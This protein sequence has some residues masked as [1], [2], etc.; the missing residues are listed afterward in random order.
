MIQR[1][2]HTVFF[3]FLCHASSNAAPPPYLMATTKHRGRVTRETKGC[4]RLTP[5]SHFV[6]VPA[7]LRVHYVSVCVPHFEAKN[8][9][10]LSCFEDVDSIHLPC[11]HTNQPATAAPRRSSPLA[12]FAVT[13]RKAAPFVLPRNCGIKNGTQSRYHHS[14]VLPQYG[15]V[16]ITRYLDRVI[17]SC[18]RSLLKK[19]ID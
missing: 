14:P 15:S 8:F 18:L 12:T 1:R 11:S 9:C 2:R 16:H 10:I 5:F 17:Y 19:I 6:C 3:W 13:E 4:V 7:G